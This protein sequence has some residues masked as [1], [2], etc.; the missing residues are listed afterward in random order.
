MS[1]FDILNSTKTHGGVKP[2]ELMDLG[3]TPIQQAGVMLLS[4]V[5]AEVT[6]HAVGRD[7]G[8]RWTMAASFKVNLNA[9]IVGGILVLLAACVSC[10]HGAP[11]A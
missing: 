6:L 9:T 8:R 4:E 10:W 11:F 3:S 1:E 5:G 7:H 2:T